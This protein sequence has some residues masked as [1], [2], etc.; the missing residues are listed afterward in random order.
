MTLARDVLVYGIS[1]GLSRI[2]GLIALPLVARKLA[3]EDFGI[4]ALVQVFAAIYSCIASLGVVTGI[5]TTYFRNKETNDRQQTIAMAV[6]LMIAASLVTLAAVYMQSGMLAVML[7]LEPQRG[8]DLVIACLG[9]AIYLVIQPYL[10]RLQFES[11]T[12][13]YGA[14]QI[15]N[16][17]ISAGAVIAAVTWCEAG[18]TGILWAM[19]T[20][21]GIT[22]MVAVAVVGRPR[23]AHIGTMECISLIR[24]GLPFVPSALASLGMLHITK[25]ILQY[26]SGPGEVGAY[27]VGASIG[28][29]LLL[30]AAAFQQAWF[31]FF[32]RHQ[33]DP[34]QGRVA[35]GAAGGL[36]LLVGTALFVLF[37]AASPETTHIIAGPAYAG[38]WP[39]TIFLGLAALMTGAFALALPGLYFSDRVGLV[40]WFQ[41]GACASTVAAGLLLVPWI[42]GLGAALATVIG[43][44][45]VVVL[46]VIWLRIHNMVVPACDPLLIIMAISGVAAGV[47]IPSLIEPIS[48]RLMACIVVISSLAG[49]YIACR[50][51]TW[52]EP[53]RA[54]G[55]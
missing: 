16:G 46:L 18:V 15:L 17:T 3:P 2:G 4:L 39:I 21:Q 43:Q 20:A 19:A 54:W 42:G 9:A 23:L 13:E 32:M 6:T 7:A 29:I 10:S 37:A 14:C 11:R 41:C 35:L 8:S 5:G 27:N 24:D 53:L 55:P 51:R 36:Y 45:V 49:L 1:A 44:A 22:L 52:R 31:P 28:A 33:S 40:A 30:A 47:A 26:N 50:P 25:V 12:M 34:D 48:V 38:S